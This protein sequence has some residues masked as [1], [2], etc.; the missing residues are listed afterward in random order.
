MLQ[1]VAPWHFDQKS[2]LPWF[3]VYPY[4]NMVL[5]QP[6]SDEQLGMREA[7]LPYLCWKQI[8]TLDAIEQ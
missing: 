7:D 2:R 8:I 6:R 5:T 3:S 4:F 1:G